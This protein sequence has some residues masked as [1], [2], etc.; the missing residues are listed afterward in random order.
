MQ[1]A[2][3]AEGATGEPVA[4]HH[5]ASEQEASSDSGVVQDQLQELTERADRLLANWQRA[6]ADL[7]N[8]RKQVERER[9]EVVS[10]ATAVLMADLL[11][12][13]DDLGRAMGT[14]AAELQGYTWVDGVRLI[15]RKLE[16]ILS[17]HGLEEVKAQGQ[18]FD[19]QVH[20]VVREVEGEAG[21][22]KEVVQ[23]GYKLGHRLLRPAIVTV[24]RQ[25]GPDT[26]AE[27]P[28]PTEGPAE[29]EGPS[30]ASA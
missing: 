17:L 26:S 16:A 9:E 1:E 2:Q 22:V 19:P 20:Q 11:P 14:V 18:P 3:P 24:G 30:E 29:Q 15:G 23:P 6:Q 5:A 12:I 25:P 27:E 7:T 21:K 13:L 28:Q 4:P 10:L 8:Y